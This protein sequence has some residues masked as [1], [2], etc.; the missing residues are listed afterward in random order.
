MSRIEKGL[1]EHHAR[2]AEQVQNSSTAA[3][4]VQ[5]GQNAPPAALEA[6]FAKVNSVVAGSPADEAGLKVGDSIIKFGWVDWTNHDRL[7]R[8]AEAVSQNEG[9]SASSTLHWQRHSLARLPAARRV[10]SSVP[11][12]D[13]TRSPSRSK[14]CDLATQGQRRL[15]RC[16]LRRGGI[17]A[18]EACWAATCC[19][20]KVHLRGGTRCYQD[21]H[22]FNNDVEVSRA[23][24]SDKAWRW[25][26]QWFM[27]WL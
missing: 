20:C 9:V 16:S 14:L 12:A 21:I 10:Y 19:H 13:N 5:A 8:V 18:D 7:G 27:C 6:P 4:Q 25:L 24:C 2:L 3:S 23:A 15:Y 17:G 22:R 26:G 1:H 11:N